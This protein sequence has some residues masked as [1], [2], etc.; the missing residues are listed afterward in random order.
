MRVSKHVW[1]MSNFCC[2]V[3]RRNIF[4][5][6]YRESLNISIVYGRCTV[7]FSSSCTIESFFY[8]DP[9]LFNKLSTTAR[10]LLYGLGEKMSR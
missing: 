5:L 4:V 8:I 7:T 3:S 10:R 6:V 1:V 9:I 2:N